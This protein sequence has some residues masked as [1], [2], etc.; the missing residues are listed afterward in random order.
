MINERVT[1]LCDGQEH[2][3]RVLDVDPLRGL[4]LCH[5]DGSRAYLRAE[6]SSVA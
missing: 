3:G 1:I 4:V 5:D 2:T 6:G